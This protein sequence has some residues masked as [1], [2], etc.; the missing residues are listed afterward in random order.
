MKCFVVFCLIVSIVVCPSYANPV[1]AAPSLWAAMAPTVYWL[2]SRFLPT[3]LLGIVVEK[4]WDLATGKPSSEDRDRLLKKLADELD[5]LHQ[6]LGNEIRSL[7]SKLDTQTTIKE[8]QRMASVAI[9]NI[10]AKAQMIE[11]QVLENTARISSNEEKIRV[12]MQSA[13]VNLEKI[14]Q[15]RSQNYE[16]AQELRGLGK[17][18]AEF[19]SNYLTAVQVEPARYDG[20]LQE[21]EAVTTDSRNL[22]A[23]LRGEALGAAADLASSTLRITALSSGTVPIPSSLAREYLDIAFGN[24][25]LVRLTYVDNDKPYNLRL[26]LSI[27]KTGGSNSQGQTITLDMRDAGGNEVPFHEKVCP[28]DSDLLPILHKTNLRNQLRE[29]LD[30]ITECGQSLQALESVYADASITASRT[31]A[32]LEQMRG[33][34]SLETVLEF[35]ERR[36]NGASLRPRLEGLTVVSNRCRSAPVTDSLI[37][38]WKCKEVDIERPQRI[39]GR[40]PAY[41]DIARYAKAEG[42]VALRFAVCKDGTTRGIEVLEEAGLGLD[43]AAVQA[44]RGWR[45]NPAICRRN[46]VSIDYTWIQRFRFLLN[47]SDIGRVEILSEDFF[48]VE[49]QED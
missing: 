39:R 20:Y 44:V 43:E 40:D 10:D 28:K 19:Q 42:V 34:Q 37:D 11:G 15:L 7:L 1:V 3:F 32:F 12:N 13:S 9:R 16:L 26:E 18:L 17:G 31:R 48:P 4:G 36:I 21:L 33:T 49:I 6:E 47:D 23:E 24:Q 29:S 2:T 5:S 38:I 25:D 46:S 30:Q 41:P 22:I 8:Y 35:Y 14:E 45:F 27:R